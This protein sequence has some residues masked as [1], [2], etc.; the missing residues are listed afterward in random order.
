MPIL[1][2]VRNASLNAIKTVFPGLIISIIGGS[3]AFLVFNNPE[4]IRGK[5]TLRAWESIKQYEELYMD[6]TDE[7]NCNMINDGVKRF[8]SNMLHQIQMTSEN[9][10]NIFD[11]EGNV[12]NLMLAI[13]NMKIDSY[14]EMKK[15]TSVLLDTLNS[16]DEKGASSQKELENIAGRWIDV[17]TRYMEECA[18]LKNRDSATINRILRELGKT[19][20]LKFE[21]DKFLA[22]TVGLR[23]KIIGKW[24]IALY[25]L[26]FELK[27]D[28]TGSW[29]PM[30]ISYPCTWQL[31][32][33][34]I[35]IKYNDGSA[36]WA[37]SVLRSKNDIL[38]IRQLGT[39]SENNSYTA[40]RQQ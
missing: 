24:S 9:L 14:N 20:S 6:N 17:H 4:K 30:D 38:S 12:D 2:S 28:G 34:T 1:S 39:D 23:N 25:K 36:H 21:E 37:F 40:C 35:R 8:N 15:L 3:F 22:D 31:D 7:I 18:Y 13:I 26:N 29:N 5:A 16:I 33:T 11:K 32:S 19:Y 27:A 10:K